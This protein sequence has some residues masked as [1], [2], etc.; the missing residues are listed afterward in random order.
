VKKVDDPDGCLKIDLRA[1]L[2]LG[3]A[4][5]RIRV[6]SEPAVSNINAMPKEIA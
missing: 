5:K 2:E 4:K 1:S 6:W 3:T